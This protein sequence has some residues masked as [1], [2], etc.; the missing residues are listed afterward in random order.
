VMH[1]TPFRQNWGVKRISHSWDSVEKRRMWLCT[2]VAKRF[3]LLLKTAINSYYTF[4][5]CCHPSHI[6][7]QTF[8]RRTCATVTNIYQSHVPA[9]EPRKDFHKSYKVT[10]QLCKIKCYVFKYYTTLPERILWSVGYSVTQNLPEQCSNVIRPIS[11]T[12]SRW[13]FGHTVKGKGKGLSTCYS[14][15]YRG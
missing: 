7:W 5:V 15:A 14:A 9:Q 6:Y 11:T 2:L 3:N 10:I 12:L 8:H 4:W 13:I 1:Y